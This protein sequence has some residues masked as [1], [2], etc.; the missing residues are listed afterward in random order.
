LARIGWLP[1]AITVGES[2]DQKVSGV[3]AAMMHHIGDLRF[4]TS[5]KIVTG[6]SIGL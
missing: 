1:A 6:Q 2:D 3:Q 4:G 5:D